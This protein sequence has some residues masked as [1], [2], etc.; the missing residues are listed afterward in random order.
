MKENAAE[1]MLHTIILQAK[2]YKIIFVRDSMAYSKEELD[3][4][5]FVKQSSRW[6][7]GGWYTLLDYV[8][9]DREI[10]KNLTTLHKLQIGAF[11]TFP[12]Y[13]AILNFTLVEG[14]ITREWGYLVWPI[15]DFSTFLILALIAYKKYSKYL[16][17]ERLDLIKKYPIYY[18][19]RY[20]AL[21]P[22]FIGLKDYL[23]LKR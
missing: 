19:E 3:L 8:L 2:G 10:Y 23:K 13:M 15:L 16:F 17:D 18:I 9:K 21:I 7:K 1:D 22:Y 5:G 12:Y 14:I 6:F 4:S 11:F 20:L